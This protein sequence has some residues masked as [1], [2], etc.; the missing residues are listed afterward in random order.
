MVQD[1]NRTQQAE[2]IVQVDSWMAELIPPFLKHRRED[3][4]SLLNYLQAGNFEAVWDLGHDIKGTGAVYGFVG[5]A[6]IGQSIEQAAQERGSTDLE[7]L[8]EELS[9][10]LDR[11]KFVYS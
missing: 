7:A 10:Y 3:I 6:R 5:L 2:I 4:A 9:N 8:A 11:V 1:S